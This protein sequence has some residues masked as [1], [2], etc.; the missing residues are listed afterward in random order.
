MFDTEHLR[1]I[2]GIAS[3][4]CF[5]AITQLAQRDTLQTDHNHRSWMLCFGVAVLCVAG[6][7][8]TFGPSQKGVISL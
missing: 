4:A 7:Y 6:V 2:Y 8:K 5:I 3:G 1:K